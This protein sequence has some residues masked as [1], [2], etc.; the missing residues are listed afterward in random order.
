MKAKKSQRNPNNL[1]LAGVFIALIIFLI[2]FSFFVKAFIVFKQSKYD[3]DN[4]LNVLISGEKYA[5]YAISPSEKKL[6]VINL[7]ESLDS[8]KDIEELLG[9]TIDAR[10]EPNGDRESNFSTH[11]LNNSKTDLNIFDRI[12]I[13]LFVKSAGSKS[14][15]SESIESD[16]SASQINETVYKL[17]ADSR[18]EDEGKTIEVINASSADGI[19]SKIARIISNIGGN[20]VLISTSK[21]VSQKS[22]LE[23]RREKGYTVNRLSKNLGIEAEKTDNESIADIV[24]IIGEDRKGDF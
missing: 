6:S 5:V 14:V 7:D 3:G 16:L 21:D 4:P 23:Y 10:I 8:E 17:I 15:V 22:T 24:V 2:I 18:I 13:L 1:N 19:G 20:V 9:I 12:R 11:L